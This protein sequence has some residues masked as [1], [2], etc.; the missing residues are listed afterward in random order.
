MFNFRSYGKSAFVFLFL[1]T[2][3]AGSTFAQDYASQG[4]S[5]VVGSAD[6]MLQRGDYAGAIPA[7]Q[8]LVSRMQDATDPEGQKS[9][10]NF[11]FQLARSFY[12]VGNPE[13]GMPILDEYLKNE[14]RTNER[15]ALR[16]MAQGF[17]ESQNWEK[18]IEFSSRLLA[19]NDLD[20][21]DQYNANLLMGQALFR[22][23]KWAESIEPLTYAAEN[24]KND[25]TTSLTQIMIVRACVESQNWRQLFVWVPRIYRTDSKYDIT[26]NLT[27]MQA[28]RAQFEEESDNSYINA[29]LLYRMVLPRDELIDYSTKRVKALT[30]KLAKD[31]QGNV[32]ESERSDRQTEIDNIKESM[33]V[34][35][36]LPPYEDEVT[37]RIGQIYAEVKRYWESY[38]LFDQLYAK[39]RTSEL[40]EAAMLQSVLILYDVN[41]VERAEERILRY[42]DERPDGQ[43]G[44]TLMVMMLRNNLVT[45]T[46][47]SLSRMVS[48][49]HYIDGF[50]ETTDEN[51][52][53]LTADLHFMLSFGYLKLRDNKSSGEQFGIIMEDYPTSS[54]LP[55]AIYYRGMT[56]LLQGKY[57]E[58]IEDFMLY[59]DKYPADEHQA[60]ALFRQGVCYF[61]MDQISDAEA[62]FTKF[63]NMY[64]DDAVVSEAHSMRGDIEAAKDGQDNPATPDVDEYDP[65]TLDRALA[66]YRIGIEK[67][68]TGMQASYAAFQGAKVYK[69]ELKWKEIIKFMDFY[70]DLWKEQA[71]VAQAVFWIGQSQIELEQISE[72]IGAYREAIE[73]YGNEIEQEGVDK[74][75]LE[76]ITIADQRLSAE[77]R[78]DLIDTLKQSMEPLGDDKAVL[79]LRMKVAIALLEG[80]EASAALGASLIKSKQDYAMTTPISLSV[81]CDAAITLNDFE[82]MN[83]LYDY[84]LATFEDSDLLWQAYRAKTMELLETG[85]DDAVLAIIQEVQDY[86]G[87]DAFMGWAQIIKAETLYRKKEYKEAENAYNLMMG[88]AEWRGPLYAKA[89]FGMGQCR[90]AAGDLDAAHSFY[91]RTYLLYKIH[92]EGKWAA[93]GYLAAANTLL[94]LDRQADAVNT[95]NKM[96]ED[97]YV[98]KRPEA[99]T[100]KE[101]LKKYGGAL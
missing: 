10:Q 27:L 15:L 71:D 89:I 70:M 51:E 64:P 95:W 19:M 79:K 3:V 34:L 67:A 18:I 37:F 38:V 41:E 75:I 2:F 77:E 62:T 30:K 57:A 33:K 26:L 22:M 78:T 16:M 1:A 32:T 84:F 8:E 31:I 39:D 11:R 59:L 25:I 12:Q 92:D 86:F 23:E 74:I 66:D 100:A 69:L 49:K 20:S 72:A 91:Q 53:M 98:N 80:D 5:S 97:E 85:D 44:R 21:E 101:M 6:A 28:G 73:V 48:R 52:K 99:K 29:L 63:I 65:L 24:S 36:D 87:A 14:P 60:N 94:E 61:G 83:A 93:M 43:Y 47:E 96:L 17:F 81:M 46:P 54:T 35:N 40:G 50:L 88:V 56:A 68:D 55:D 82:Q 42:L 9:V 58:A 13:A 7:L 90:E 76:L 45:D 4:I